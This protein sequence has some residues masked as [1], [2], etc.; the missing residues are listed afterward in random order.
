MGAAQDTGDNMTDYEYQMIATNGIKLHVVQA[1]PQDGPLVI[2]LHGFPEFWYG[3]KNQM[4]A[5]AQRGFRVWVPDQRG[6]NLS[7]KPQGVAAYKL[8]LLAADIIGLIDAS[9]QEQVYLAGHDWGGGVAWWIAIN[10]P[11]RL[12]KLVIANVPHPVVFDQHLRSSLSQ[13]LKSWYFLLFQLPR[14]PEF[15]IARNGPK[16]LRNSS[17]PGSF[18]D[19]DL[20]HYQVAWSQ[21]GALTAMVNWYRA[22]FRYRPST[23]PAIR[24]RVPTLMLWGAQDFALSSEM[25]QESIE[26]CDDGRLVFFEDATHWVQHDKADEVSALMADFFSEA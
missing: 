8:D 16:G 24:V 9:G 5:L 14:L 25:A 4:D 22:I 17:L 13:R 11:Q 23:S 1:G 6:Y 21:P 19:D 26:L 18:S 10:H 3:W 2:L 20:N 12:K 15:V 7:D